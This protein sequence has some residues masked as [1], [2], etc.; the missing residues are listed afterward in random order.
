MVDINCR[1]KVVF[2]DGSGKFFTDIMRLKE[3]W[4]RKVSIK[5]SILTF[6][7]YSCIEVWA[8]SICNCN[9]LCFI[10]RFCLW[11]FHNILFSCGNLKVKFFFLKFTITNILI[12]LLWDFKNQEA[13]QFPCLLMTKVIM[14][15]L[16]AVLMTS[17]SLPKYK[18]CMSESFYRRSELKAMG[19]WL[20]SLN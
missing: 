11:I 6:M 17:L 7:H 3:S 8:L 19:M 16:F 18:C 9:I 12:L 2:K 13:L 14:D 5:F 20:A 1:L 15:I 10:I 4:K